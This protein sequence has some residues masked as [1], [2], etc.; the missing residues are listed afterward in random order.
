MVSRT[1]CSEDKL[2]FEIQ[3]AWDGDNPGFDKFQVDIR[4]FAAWEFER[5]KRDGYRPPS[6]LRLGEFRPRGP[7]GEPARCTHR[8]SRPYPPAQTAG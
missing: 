8:R 6:S 2:E 3:F 1:A 7:R 5:N 4:C